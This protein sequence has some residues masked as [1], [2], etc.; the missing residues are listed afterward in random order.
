M[1]TNKDTPQQVRDEA[2]GMVIRLQADLGRDRGVVPI[3]AR[4]FGVTR[5]AVHKWINQAA[6]RR[7]HVVAGPASARVAH[8]E[9]EVGDLQQDKAILMATV[10][11]LMQ[12]WDV[13][14][15]PAEPNWPTA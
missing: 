9:R 2:V 5:Q 13:S 1:P 8:L 14:Y 10:A 12:E 4:R 11:V 15:A 6:S 7:V 3:V